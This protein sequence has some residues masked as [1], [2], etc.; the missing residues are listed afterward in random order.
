MA[1]GVRLF[2]CFKSLF[3]CLQRAAAL[4]G[5]AISHWVLE[6]KTNIG[7]KKRKSEVAEKKNDLLVVL[8]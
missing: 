5:L 3:V 2:V 6:Q 7:A 8:Q 4:A 1:G